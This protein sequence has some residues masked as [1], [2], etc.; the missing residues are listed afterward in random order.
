MNYNDLFVG[1]KAMG[2][3]MKC[4]YCSSVESKVT[5]SRPTEDNM[6]I[7]R[8]RE[9]IKCGG[10]FTTYECIEHA[11]LIVVKKDK[12]RQPFDRNK[13][14][15]GLLRAC[16]KRNVSI[17]ALE[18]IV[19]DIEYY[20]ANKLRKE[21]SSKELGEKALEYL[22][23]LDDVAYVRFASVYREFADIDSFMQE[24]KNFKKEG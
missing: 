3:I 17:N 11:P 16:E 8:R 5:D 21:I 6:K 23:N 18:K 10:R 9:C 14:L 12:T 1:R 22:K 20:Y 7:R 13:M 2:I 24:L 4:P 15:N 19:D